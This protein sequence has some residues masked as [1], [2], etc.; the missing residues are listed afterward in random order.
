MVIPLDPAFGLIWGYPDFGENPAR[1]SYSVAYRISD[2]SGPDNPY[3]KGQNMTNSSNGYQRLGMYIN[4][5]TKRVGFI[6]NG[7]DQGINLL[8]LLHLK[9]YVF[10]LKWYINIF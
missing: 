1:L 8:Y 10:C 4:Q 3:Y 6:L 2:N 9:I 7:V 5:N